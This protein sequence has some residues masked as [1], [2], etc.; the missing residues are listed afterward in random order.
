MDECREPVQNVIFE[1]PKP[2]ADTAAS[3]SSS[4]NAVSPIKTFSMINWDMKRNDMPASLVGSIPK[5][6]DK[7]MN[8]TTKF[9]VDNEEI[10][11]VVSDEYFVVL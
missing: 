4:S 10:F 3:S 9:M 11:T 8:S 2:S 6:V 5:P 1:I 7:A